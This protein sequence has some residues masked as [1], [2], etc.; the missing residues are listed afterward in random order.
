MEGEGE[1]VDG[2][3]EGGGGEGEAR[4]G[5]GSVLGKTPGCLLRPRVGAR[6]DEHRGT[7]HPAQH[8]A[9][10]DGATPR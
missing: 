3:G 9:T 4:V 5:R 6:H 8:P 7:P 2:V 1:R 10:A